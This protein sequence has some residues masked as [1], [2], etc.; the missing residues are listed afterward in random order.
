MYIG[1]WQEYKLAKLIKHINDNDRK[2]PDQ[3]L[4][5]SQLRRPP[6]LRRPSS[7]DCNDDAASVASST[8]SG[9]SFKSTQSAPVRSSPAPS[10][11]SAQTRLN[12]YY[13][14]WERGSRR[15]GLPSPAA[16]EQTRRLPPRPRSSSGRPKATAKRKA[17]AKSGP[18][19]EEERRARILSMKRLYGLGE[20]EYP[21]VPLEVTAG[22]QV[23]ASNASNSMSRVASAATMAPIDSPVAPSTDVQTSCTP[24]F[25]RALTELQASITVREEAC[26]LEPFSAS[27]H[28][29][30]L[31]LSISGDSMG[32]SGGLIAWSKNLRPDDLSPCV[33]LASL[34]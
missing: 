5:A 4:P 32:G 29:D 33:T 14:H 16:S 2:P 34:F 13:E 9:I 22:Y 30:P 1:P 26:C 28:D 31:A 7:K 15:D 23:P 19:F 21:E 6:L 12:D 18:S 17:K 25:D 27:R 10:S 24:D 11:S 8:R 20:P 3:Q